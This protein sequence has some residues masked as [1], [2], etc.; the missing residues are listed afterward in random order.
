MWTAQSPTPL[1]FSPL[2]QCCGTGGNTCANSAKPSTP[3]LA[4]VA[5][6]YVHPICTLGG[7]IK[8]DSIKA[9]KFWFM[10][11]S[12]LTAAAAEGAPA[13]PA[14]LP[15]LAP[16]RWRQPEV[17]APFWE[18]VAEGRYPLA[19][20]YIPYENRT[21]ASVEHA[22]LGGASDAASG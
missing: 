16:L 11:D 1:P 20:T 14:E 10:D 17:E 2:L 3:S 6:L 4:P 8:I 9:A 19:F 15:R 22:S 18:C 5:V 21:A 13:V 12:N 7:S